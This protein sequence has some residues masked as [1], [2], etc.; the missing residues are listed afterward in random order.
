M[1]ASAATDVIE[2][3]TGAS[4]RGRGIGS[5]LSLAA[6]AAAALSIGGCASARVVGRTSTPGSS[7]V[8]VAVFDRDEDEKAARPTQQAIVTSLREVSRHGRVVLESSEGA[9]TRADLPP[10]RYRLTLEGRRAAS[11]KLHRLASDN[12]EEFDLKPGETVDLHVVL[13]SDRETARILFTPPLLLDTT[14]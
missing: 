6:L 5:A 7:A 8:R 2:W 11:G 14:Q 1:N 3:G 12:Y 4:C 10:G 9:W 13:H